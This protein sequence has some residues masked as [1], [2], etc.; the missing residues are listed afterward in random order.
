MDPKLG[1]ALFRLLADAF[2]GVAAARD[3]LRALAEMPKRPEEFYEWIQTHA[4]N[5]GDLVRSEVFGEQYDEWLRLVGF[6][7]RS[8]YL[9]LLERY[10]IL[11]SKMEE[12]EK[13]RQQVQSKLDPSHVASELLNV[14]GT[15]LEK[16]LQ[17]Q[18]QWIDLILGDNE[19]RSQGSEPDGEKNE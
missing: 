8:R 16:T 1:E 10:E 3:A 12:A 19:T 9:E 6:V 2:K 15:T 5:L 18:K 17:S 11:H 7:P 4:P 13:T 14:M